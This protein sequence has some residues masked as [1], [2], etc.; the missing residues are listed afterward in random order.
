MSGELAHITQTFENRMALRRGMMR[1]MGII[2]R[3]D[4]AQDLAAP[5]RETLLSCNR[6]AQPD[7]CAFWLGSSSSDAPM[8]CRARL[9]F[10]EIARATSRPPEAPASSRPT[11]DK[12]AANLTI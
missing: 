6:C 5:L 11:P 7:L 3:P 12:G 1:K 9:A 2:D 10:E 8:F 4:L